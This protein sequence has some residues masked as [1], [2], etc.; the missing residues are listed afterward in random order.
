M[1]EQ[2]Y[3]RDRE[4]EQA[5]LGDS[6]AKRHTLSREGAERRRGLR[7]FLKTLRSIQTQLEKL[8]RLVKRIVQRRRDLP[9]L[10]DLEDIVD[11]I[12]TANRL[13]DPVVNAIELLRNIW[14]F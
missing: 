12:Q 5:V 9:S 13:F 7:S 14:Q 4:N 6:M 1:R 2:Q 3:E 8:E 11:M 10:K